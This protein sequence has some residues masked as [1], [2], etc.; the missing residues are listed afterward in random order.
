M[1]KSANICFFNTTPFWGGGE[2]WHFEAAN[3]AS[4]HGYNTFFVCGKSSELSKKLTVSSVNQFHIEVS[5]RSFLNPLKSSKLTSFFKENNIDVVLFNS[6]KDLKIGGPAAKKAGVKSIAYRRGIA[7]EVKQKALTKKLFNEVVTH[8]IFNSKATKELLVKHY[9]Q[10]DSTKKTAIIYN[11]LEVPSDVIKPENNPLII[12]N[13]G[14][15]VEQKNQ[16]VI[17]KI[18]H[19][20]KSKGLSFEFRIAGEGPLDSPIE[21]AIKKNGVEDHVQM[22][23]F[24][25]DMSEFM[26]NIDIFISTATWEGFGFVLAEAMSHKVPVVA[27]DLSSNPELVQHERTGFLI[28]PNDLQ[29]FADSLEKLIKDSALRDQMATASRAF[30]KDHFE[31]ENQFKKLMEFVLK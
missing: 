19:L 18:A 12:G 5:N 22:L 31:A 16:V 13:A 7:V 25:D 17:P 20:L 14:R 29:A 6:P 2:K 21:A 24:V 1:N 3:Q 23:G 30:V 9:P 8:F 11:A 26:S 15:L 27:F 4:K 28:P 10:V